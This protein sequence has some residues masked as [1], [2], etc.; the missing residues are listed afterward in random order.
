MD[1][2]NFLVYQLTILP[3]TSESFE[4]G[5]VAIKNI[6]VRIG[7]SLNGIDKMIKP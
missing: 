3:L 1:N 5:K 4:K 2:L 7:Y 6:E